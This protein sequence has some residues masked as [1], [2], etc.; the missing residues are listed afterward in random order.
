MRT[1]LS[2]FNLLTG[3]FFFKIVVS[4]RDGGSPPKE[5]FA[6]VAVHVKD[7][8]DNPPRFLDP[9]ENGVTFYAY[10]SM[11]GNVAKIKVGYLITSWGC[12]ILRSYFVPTFNII[13]LG[14]RPGRRNQRRHN[15]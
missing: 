14:R 6:N 1:C 10:K 8:N 9:S 4:A 12:F 2:S 5:A 13:P 11:T 3:S 7:V 15:L